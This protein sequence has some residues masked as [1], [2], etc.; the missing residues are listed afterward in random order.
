MS[1]CIVSFFVYG[2]LRYH[3]GGKWHEK[4]LGKTLNLLTKSYKTSPENGQDPFQGL[5]LC[6]D[7]LKIV[8]SISNGRIVHK[9][10]WHGCRLHVEKLLPKSLEVKS[11]EFADLHKCLMIVYAAR[12]NDDLQNAMSTDNGLLE[13]M[14]SLFWNAVAGNEVLGVEDPTA[15]DVIKHLK[16][17]I[18]TNVT[19][20]TSEKFVR[21]LLDYPE[22]FDRVGLPFYAR[23]IELQLQGFAAQFRKKLIEYFERQIFKSKT[24]S[25]LY[26]VNNRH[27]FVILPFFG[28][29]EDDYQHSSNGAIHKGIYEKQ[30]LILE[31]Y[32][33]AMEYQWEEPPPHSVLRDSIL[34]RILLEVGPQYREK[35]E[36]CEIVD[37]NAGVQTILNMVEEVDVLMNMHGY[38]DDGEII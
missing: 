14:C 29:P 33:V 34:H 13:W 25:V 18:N 3:R 10:Q 16:R 36:T 6:G 38:N 35:F 22:D 32:K 27:V 7:Q 8:G 5:S 21:K 23:E 28:C 26:P 4:G 30:M 20:E 2:Q 15:A 9:L 19:F 12:A 11:G 17:E 1:E 31:L 24:L 37:A